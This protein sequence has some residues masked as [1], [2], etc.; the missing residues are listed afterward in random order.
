MYVVEGLGESTII[1]IK[2]Q[3]VMIRSEQEGHMSHFSV[4]QDIYYRIDPSRFHLFAADDG[5][6]IIPREEEEEL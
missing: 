3:D 2:A 5:V 6:R 1:T 4:N